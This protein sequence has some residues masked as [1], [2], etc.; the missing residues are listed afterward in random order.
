MEWIKQAFAA[1]ALMVAGFGSC[2]LAAAQETGHAVGFQQVQ[3]PDGAGGKFLA[4]LWYPTTAAPRDVSLP[5]QKPMSVAPDGPVAGSGL[6]L[7]VI[8]HGNGGGATG[9]VDLAMALAAAGYVVAAPMHQGD[10][11]LDQSAVGSADWLAGRN[12]QLRAATDYVL[13]AWPQHEH[14]DP[15]RVG[16]YGFSA[17][18]FTVL[19]AVGARPDLTVIPGHCAKHPEIACQVL[20]LARSPLLQAGA[21][22]P[23]PQADPRIRAAVVAAPGFGFTMA[24]QAL[25]QVKA[26]VQLWEA[27]QDAN[28]EYATNT[29][30]VREGL[31]ARAEYHSVAGASHMSFLAPCPGGPPFLC[32]DAAGFDRTAFHAQM[33][34]RVIGFFDRHL[35]PVTPTHGG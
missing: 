16:A 7:V 25:A 35:G 28:V 6:A 2:S 5:G 15:Q 33:N 22:I 23:E 9:H 13:G 29:R 1:V 19:V 32:A 10:N 26:P 27:D 34:A 4:A 31:G 8:S 20:A 24:N 21:A 14:V 30:V 17:G 3:V 11:F 18:G 12:R